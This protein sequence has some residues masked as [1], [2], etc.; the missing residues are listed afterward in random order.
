MLH[1][2]HH[3]LLFSTFPIPLSL[4]TITYHHPSLPSLHFLQRPITSTITITTTV[5]AIPFIVAWLAKLT[6]Q[7]FGPFELPFFSPSSL[8]LLND[9]STLQVASNV[10]FSGAIT[11]FFHSIQH[12][13]KCAKE[14]LRKNIISSSFFLPKP[15]LKFQ[16]LSPSPTAT[17]SHHKSSLSSIETPHR[18]EPFNQS[19][20]FQLGLR[21]W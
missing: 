14:L 16:A 11:V 13:T 15:F 1:S 4:S 21:L 6:T 17:I 18:E 10:L 12:H 19:G 9:P 3:H 2:H 5:S 8:L 7:G 20:I